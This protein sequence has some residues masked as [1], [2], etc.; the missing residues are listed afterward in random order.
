MTLAPY[1]ASLKAIP[2]P[3]PVLEAVM[4]TTL[5]F[6]KNNILNEVLHQS[7]MPII[8]VHFQL[9]IFTFYHLLDISIYYEDLRC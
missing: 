7:K 3:M 8:F 5:P 2:L 6:I 1:C 4:M 9:D